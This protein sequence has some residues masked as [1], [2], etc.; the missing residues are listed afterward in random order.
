MNVRHTL[1]RYGWTSHNMPL[2]NNHYYRCE[3]KVFLKS[4]N[5]HIG[6]GLQQ[7]Q[8]QKE[9][10]IYFTEIYFWNP[11]SEQ[12]SVR[13]VVAEISSKLQFLATSLMLNLKFL[14][15]K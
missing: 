15:E 13:Y 7:P 8:L 10:K 11:V 3:K 4:S 5:F 9:N 1:F 6:H 12:W 14:F 2:F